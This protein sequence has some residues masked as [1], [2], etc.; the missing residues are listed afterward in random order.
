[1]IDIETASLTNVC[2]DSHT[3]N[4]KNGANNPFNRLRLTVMTDMKA[5]VV[6]TID[7]RFKLA[8]VDQ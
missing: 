3:E 4:L 7:R 2:Q 5:V 1:M 8:N 6:N